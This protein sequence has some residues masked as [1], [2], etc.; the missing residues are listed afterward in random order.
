MP[1]I[2]EQIID[3]KSRGYRAKRISKELNVSLNTVKSTLRRS[4]TEKTCL[5]LCKN[6]GKG[7]E[8]TSNHK[9]VFCCDKCRNE[10]WNKRRKSIEKASGKKTVCAC[11]GK[12]FA[13]YSHKG[14]KYCSHECYI[15]VRYKSKAADDEQR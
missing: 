13:S 8:N 3:L 10:W 4:N 14:Q 9:K 15:R 1:E 5:I 12:E 2:K 7:I 6:C 11:C